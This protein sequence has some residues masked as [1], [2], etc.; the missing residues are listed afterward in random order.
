MNKNKR[1]NFRDA[2]ER[3]SCLKS[4][5]MCPNMFNSHLKT[6]ALRI[7]GFLQRD[8][9]GDL[10]IFDK[11]KAVPCYGVAVNGTIERSKVGNFAADALDYCATR[12]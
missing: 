3:I 9:N 12:I 7:T 1:D 5:V 4:S 10:R 6:S 11:A 8:S 2:Y